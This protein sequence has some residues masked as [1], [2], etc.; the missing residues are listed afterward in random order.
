MTNDPA[1]DADW[2]LGEVNSLRERARAD[3]HAFRFPLL[4]FGAFTLATAP[5]Y[6]LGHQQGESG[7]RAW[8]FLA[9]GMDLVWL[10]GLVVGAVLTIWWYRRHGD[11]S[12]IQ[13]SARKSV[14]IWTTAG[15]APL[16]WILLLPLFFLWPFFVR[17]NFGLLA[18]ALGLI[19]LARAER[20]RRLWIIT[21]LYT[22]A[23]VPAVVYNMENQYY[24]LFH[25]FGF[26]SED[27][28]YALVQGTPV[29]LPA[30]ILLIGG[31][32]TRRTTPA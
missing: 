1:G 17:D 4:Y 24:R 20:S 11:R 10:A 19:A 29:L 31:L 16:L 15:A 27:M 21:G 12:G 28:P 14:L 32:T 18:V 8:P 3:R 25:L 23:A 5:L 9:R 22:A 30:L 26:T 6:V 7:F 13:T 2:L